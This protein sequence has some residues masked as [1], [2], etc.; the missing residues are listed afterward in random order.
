MIHFKVDVNNVD[1]NVG[2]REPRIIEFSKYAVLDLEITRE[3]S[4]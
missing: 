1:N 3:L 2:E 4:F